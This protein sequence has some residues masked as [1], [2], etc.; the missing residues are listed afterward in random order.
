MIDSGI[1]TF[2]KE[3]QFKKQLFPSND[4]DFDNLTF[5]SEAQSEKH[6]KPNCL[7]EAG[8]SIVSKDTHL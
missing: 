4:N 3:Q 1:S 6:P 8:I 5:L 2:S 7:T